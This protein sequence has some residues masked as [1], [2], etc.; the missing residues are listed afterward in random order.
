[1][2]ISLDAGLPSPFFYPLYITWYFSSLGVTDK[3]FQLV[4]LKLSFD[5]DI[6]LLMDKLKYENVKSERLQA[7]WKVEFKFLGMEYSFLS[8]NKV[9]TE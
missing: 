5:I 7:N 6:F 1:M 4:R 8:P 3:T 2:I 9:L